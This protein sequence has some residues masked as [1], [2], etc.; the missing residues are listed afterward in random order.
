[1]EGVGGVGRECAESADDVR[2]ADSCCVVA[3]GALSDR[4]LRI[5]SCLPTSAALPERNCIHVRFRIH[6][7]TLQVRLP[8]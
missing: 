1:M 5:F 8:V 4:L 6:A 7:F 3:A 2:S